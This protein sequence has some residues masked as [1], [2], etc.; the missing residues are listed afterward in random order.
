MSAGD[1]CVGE[2]QERKTE[3]Y[4]NG[5]HHTRLDREG[6]SGRRCERPGS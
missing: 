1:G 4:A 3:A 5:H 2:E 6:I